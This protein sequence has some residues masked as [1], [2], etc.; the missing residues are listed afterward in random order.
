MYLECILTAYD[1]KI[2]YENSTKLSEYTYIYIYIYI[3]IYKLI[4]GDN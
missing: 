3:Y 1:V 2:K 4:S